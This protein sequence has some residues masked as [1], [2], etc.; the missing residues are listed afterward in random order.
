MLIEKTINRIFADNQLYTDKII[1]QISTLISGVFL[2]LLAISGN[3]IAETLGCQT[4][5]ML[6]NNILIKHAVTLLICSFAINFASNLNNEVISPHH[7]AINTICIYI[8]FIIFTKCTVMFQGIIFALLFCSFISLN[9]IRFFENKDSKKDQKDQLFYS[10]L[11]NI[12]KKS[13]IILYIL[14]L[15]NLL[16]GHFKYYKKQRKDH[17]KNWSYWTFLF[18]K[19]HCASHKS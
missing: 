10:N 3:F 15:I 17:H 5:R 14:I 11:N 4:R 16:I 19:I 12:L 18:G 1:I 6:K 7:L 13:N 2:L 8:H 9:Y